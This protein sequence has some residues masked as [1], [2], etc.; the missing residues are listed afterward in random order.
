MC[1]GSCWRR[2][3]WRLGRKIGMSRAVNL[4]GLIDKAFTGPTWHGPALRELLAD[5]T[6]AEAAAHPLAGLHSIWEQV[7]HVTTWA[8]V[9]LRRI[10]GA[11]GEPTEEE[12]WPAAPAA[13]PE[14]W[15]AAV[16]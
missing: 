9:A 12:N 11:L 14:A 5:V 4:A 13:T 7:L 16:E 3:S 6:P 15:A 2:N 8:E 1:C 10:D